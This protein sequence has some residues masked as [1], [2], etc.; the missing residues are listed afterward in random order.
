MILWQ[1]L[2]A[3]SI[4]EKNAIMNKKKN[5]KRTIWL[6]VMIFIITGGFYYF[7]ISTKKTTSY[8]TVLAKREKIIQTVSETGT[9]KSSS[10]VNLSFQNA[11]KLK[12]ISTK[13]GNVVKKG[14]VLA[15]LD[16]SDILIRKN[17]A[18]A[19]LDIANQ[20]LN[21]LL[22]G[23]KNVD[24]NVA[25]AN[26]TQ[27]E[28]SY[29]SAR[30]DYDKAKTVAEENVRQAQKNYNDLINKTPADLTSLEQAITTAETSL[31]NA[32][33]LYQNALDNSI[34]SSIVALDDKLVVVNTALDVITRTL[35]DED[36]KDQHGGYSSVSSAGSCWRSTAR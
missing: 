36:G 18:Q 32:Q 5:F 17:E 3:L 8:E 31:R 20:E 6:L 11:G 33:N 9:I 7:K 34:E 25:K 26:A 12:N 27:A 16:Y 21:K 24:I 14:Q 35:D 15:E 1:K 4:T 19:S 23:A 30:K 22:A 29:E 10:E 2:S 28:T 13:V